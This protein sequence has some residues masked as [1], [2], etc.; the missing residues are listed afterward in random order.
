MFADASAEVPG[1]KA[2]FTVDELNKSSEDLARKHPSKVEVFR[3]GNSRKGEQ[4]RALR[5]GKGRNTALLFGFPHPNEPIGSNTLE[6]LSW[7]HVED[8]SLD[9]LDS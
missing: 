1:Y 9:E 8:R 3:I 6:Y 2:F 5:I 4:I 7:R